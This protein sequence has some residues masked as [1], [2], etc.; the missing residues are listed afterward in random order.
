MAGRKFP[1]AAS[2]EAYWRE[3][4]N[5]WASSGER[6][7]GYCKAHHLCAKSVHY[8][9][10]VLAHRAL[11]LAAK[12]QAPVFAELRIASPPEAAIEIALGNGRRVQVRAG[13]DEATL[14]QVVAVLERTG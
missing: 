14:A 13:F 3:H 10:K 7:V 4:V 12:G 11:P 5:C 1:D 6:I 2:R 9:K 8:W